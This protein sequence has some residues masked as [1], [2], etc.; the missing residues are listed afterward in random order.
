VATAEKVTS[1][2]EGQQASAAPSISRPKGGGAVHGIG[3][4]SGANPVTSTGSLAH[5][6]GHRPG[7][8]GGRPSASRSYDS[9]SGSAL[10]GFGWSLSLPAI[11]S[12]K[13]A[14]GLPR[15]RGAEESDVCALSGAED[16]VPVMRADGRRRP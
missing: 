9:G 1:R 5:P 8:L 3:E 7:L 14:T 10:F 2:S 13:T 6:T 15:Y 16:L 4:K 11:A 12:K